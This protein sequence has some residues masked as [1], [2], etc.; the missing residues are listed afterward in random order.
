MPLQTYNLP[1]P[2]NVYRKGMARHAPTREFAK[3]IAQSLPTIIGAFK[4]A[5]TKH[6][7]ITRNTQGRP[8][9]QRNYYEHVIRDER[10]LFAIRK[11]IR[12]NPLN[13]DRDED[14]PVNI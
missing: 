10:K 14:N 4:S 3:P 9:W 12:N 11:Y 6:I 7:N 2:N 13:W 8:V 1:N 5:V